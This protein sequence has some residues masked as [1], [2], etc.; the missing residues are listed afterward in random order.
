VI[1]FCLGS[2]VPGPG[3]VIGAALGGIIGGISA[4]NVAESY[5]NNLINGKSL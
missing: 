2:I 5:F 4:Y 3:N 1:G